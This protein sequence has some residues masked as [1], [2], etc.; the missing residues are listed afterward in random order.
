MNEVKVLSRFRDKYLLTNPVG[1]IF[2][3]R[4][5]KTSPPLADFIRRHSILK[6]VARG[7]LKPLI[8]MGRK[9]E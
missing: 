5:Y 3:G 6:N 4:Y 1:R 7:V 2:V 8:W 9:A